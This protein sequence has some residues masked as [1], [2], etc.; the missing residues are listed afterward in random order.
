MNFDDVINECA[1]T[2][3]KTQDAEITELTNFL[4][5][6][7]GENSKPAVALAGFPLNRSECWELVRAF[8]G[9]EIPPELRSMKTYDPVCIIFEYSD[10]PGFIGS[11][12]SGGTIT[13][14]LPSEKLKA[15]RVA[16]IDSAASL[17]R[18]LELSGTL[19]AICLCVN[20]T[21]AMT[22]T[23]RVWLEGFAKN[24]YSDGNLYIAIT[25]TDSLNTEEEV[26]Q[27]RDTVSGFLR[28][29]NIKAQVLS[30]PKQAMNIMQDFL[31]RHDTKEIHGRRVSR[32]VLKAIT[33]RVRHFVDEELADDESIADTLRQLEKQKR[34]LELSGKAAA[35]GVLSNLMNGLTAEI[36]DG[37]RDYGRQMA[38][39]ISSYIAKASMGELEDID[40]K[41]NSYINGTWEKYFADKGSEID[42]KFHDIAAR[43]TDQM[44]IDAGELIAGLDDQARRTMYSALNLKAQRVMD[45]ISSDAKHNSGTVSVNE[46][47][48]SLRRETR[49]MMMLSIPLLFVNPMI[50]AGN[51]VAAKLLENFRMSGKLEEMRSE[52]K[53]QVEDVCF[54]NA[55]NIVRQIQQSFRDE[56]ARASENV[57]SAYGG[58]IGRIEDDIAKLRAE[59]SRRAEAREFLAKQLNETYPAL[60]AE[61]ISGR[62]Q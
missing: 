56:T 43:L 51:L 54:A 42:R 58:L 46:I 11:S 47:T 26:M 50:S 7:L 38:D 34:S 9:T 48:D 25:K 45:G 62:Q 37:V 19:D 60:E 32:V 33:E 2:S 39:S 44:D 31:S 13:Y 21:M 15:Q 59:N 6:S 22:Q 35:D 1:L 41:I 29:H 16:I 10:T 27:V 3:A 5:A 28:R 12:E 24:A 23:E 49:N 4:R 53:G 20:A 17:E 61:L 18:W 40:D 36:C 55:E 8:T 52:M 30:D 57:R 14:G